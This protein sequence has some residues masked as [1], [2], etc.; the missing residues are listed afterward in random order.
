MDSSDEID[1]SDD[2]FG[3]DISGLTHHDFNPM[4]DTLHILGDEKACEVDS[5][6]IRNELIKTHALPFLPAKAL[7][8]FKSVS[9][10]WDKRISSPLLAHHQ[11]FSFRKLSGFFY[12]TFNGLRFFSLDAA[13]YGVPRPL[14]DFLPA[15]NHLMCSTN[16]LLLFRCSDSYYVCNP[17]TGDRN[18]LPNPRY[19]HGTDPSAV[20]AYEPSLNNI[21]AY[22]QVICAF[23]AFDSPVVFFEIYSSETRS[24]RISSAICPELE[25][26]DHYGD[27]FYLNGCAYW[28]ISSPSPSPSAQL[29][30]FDVQSEECGVLSVPSDGGVFTV[31][32]DEI[33]YVTSQKHLDD[34]FA[35]DI[36][37]GLEMGLKRSVYLNLSGFTESKVVPAAGADAGDCLLILCVAEDGMQVLQKYGLSEQKVKVLCSPC[38]IALHARLLPYVNSLAI[39]T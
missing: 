28:E 9:S 7:L 23:T 31:V 12:Q 22:Y 35:F 4:P 33:C 15:D 19:Y 36:Y 10:E 26:S 8:R 38:E 37:G 1:I 3:L 11:S 29:L 13:A 17:A 2:I 14:L 32:G 30:A 21:E 25:D 5:E 24:W 16:G 27:G 20:L 34:V 39:V 6:I 18:M